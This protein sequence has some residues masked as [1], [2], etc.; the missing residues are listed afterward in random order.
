MLALVNK[1]KSTICTTAFFLSAISVQAVELRLNGSSSIDVIGADYVNVLSDTSVLSTAYSKDVQ[2]YLDADVEIK[3]SFNPNDE[4]KLFWNGLPLNVTDSDSQWSFFN[5]LCDEAKELFVEQKSNNWFLVTPDSKCDGHQNTGN[6]IVTGLKINHQLSPHIQPQR[7]DSSYFSPDVLNTPFDQPFF[8]TGSLISGKPG[9]DLFTFP[10]VM[11]GLQQHP[12]KSEQLAFLENPASY[13]NGEITVF[14][15]N[16]PISKSDQKYTPGSNVMNRIVDFVDSEGE[17]LTGIINVMTELGYIPFEN[18]PLITEEEFS[19]AI[20]GSNNLVNVQ[21]VINFI[22]ELLRKHNPDSPDIEN[23]KIQDT[24][25]RII[26]KLSVRL[27]ETGNEAAGTDSEVEGA[28]IEEQSDA[29]EEP[30]V[31]ATGFS[32]TSN[33]AQSFTTPTPQS[34]LVDQLINR[35]DNNTNRLVTRLFTLFPKLRRLGYGEI[36]KLIRNPDNKNV[37][38]R[39]LLEILQGLDNFE[40]ILRQELKRLLQEEGDDQSSRPKKTDKKGPKRS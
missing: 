27:T 13:I 19:K 18:T 1:N 15:T 28:N 40:K 36:K 26:M 7:Q 23:N 4:M 39:R 9:A 6:Q 31:G 10:D 29:S 33:N 35:Y 11:P 16:H 12:L 21:R 20:T 37:N 32:T 2:V 17:L 24:V 8:N 14:I 3:I 34:V 5:G 22:K 38:S 25:K 30:V